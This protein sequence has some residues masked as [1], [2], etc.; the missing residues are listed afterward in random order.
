MVHGACKLGGLNVAI[1]L[2]YMKYK[3]ILILDKRA[4]YVDYINADM[5]TKSLYFM[6]TQHNLS[7]DL[8][9]LN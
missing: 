4:H 5:F 8:I 2:E 7:F 3:N 9:E 6:S 1:R